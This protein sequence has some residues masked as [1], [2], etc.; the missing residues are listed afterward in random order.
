MRCGDGVT[1]CNLI[2]KRGAGKVRERAVKFV[3]AIRE[4]LPSAMGDCCSTSAG[5]QDASD[6]EQPGA[7]GSVQLRQDELVHVLKPTCTALS[8]EPLA[9]KFATIKHGSGTVRVHKATYDG[10]AP[11]EDRSTVVVGP[12]FVFC[13]VWD[14]HGGTPCSEYIESHAFGHFA[15]GKRAGKRTAEVWE[16]CFR[17]L[18][19]DYLAHGMASGA[20]SGAVD[21][22]EP[23][24]KILFA[25]ACCTGCFVDLRQKLHCPAD[26]FELLLRNARLDMKAL[27]DEVRMK[28]QQRR[29]RRA[30]I[31]RMATTLARWSINGSVD[32]EENMAYLRIKVNGEVVGRTPNRAGTTPEWNTSIVLHGMSET[33]V[34]TVRVEVVVE[35]EVGG[36]VEFVGKGASA[37]DTCRRNL[38]SFSIVEDTVTGDGTA[39][40]VGKLF[41]QVQ[42]GVNVGIGNLGDSRAVLGRYRGGQLRTLQLSRDHS[43]TDA[44][45]C[46]RLAQEHPSVDDA[47]APPLIDP[48]TERVKA[49]CAFTRSIGDFQMKDSVRLANCLSVCLPACLPICP[50]LSLSLLIEVD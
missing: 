19:A 21:G 4:P 26:Q 39:A 16:H 41:C 36:V 5:L 15:D 46:E 8:T 45:E 7:R 23:D 35:D 18:D 30:S 11:S 1:L 12:D 25:G 29:G 14:G 9:S 2:G 43:V 10:N 24:P 42:A 49:I 31:E 27:Q 50:S 44:D 3:T 33:D 38:R 37:F 48:Q 20:G 13:G 22:G 40:S 34:N 28:K 47:E 32:G 6:G 17:S